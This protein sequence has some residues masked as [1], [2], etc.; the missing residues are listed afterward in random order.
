[1]QLLLAILSVLAAWAFLMVLLVGLLRILK[2]LEGVR[3]GLQRITM[4]VRA[5]EQETLPLRGR[6]EALGATLAGAA[7]ALDVGAGR[8]EQIGGGRGAPGGFGRPA[9]R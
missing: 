7:E 6:L 8:L 1:M 4:G 5:I 2:A 9:G 3:A